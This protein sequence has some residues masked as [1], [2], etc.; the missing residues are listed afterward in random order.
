MATLRIDTIDFHFKPAIEARKYDEFEYYI[1]VLRTEGMRA[2][3]IIAVDSGAKPQ[4]SWTI[5]VKDYRVMRGQPRDFAPIQIAEDFFRKVKDT[6]AGLVEVAANATNPD[7]R[8]HAS[9][10]L[11]AG[12]SQVVFHLEPYAGPATKLF[13]KDPTAGVINKL[14]QMF[15][16]MDPPLLVLSIKTSREVKVPW[17]AS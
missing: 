12:R 1:G 14:N 5:E 16:K 13:P 17:T 2:V 15:G 6:Q 3:D 11:L 10:A 4:R 7:E 8:T 9:L